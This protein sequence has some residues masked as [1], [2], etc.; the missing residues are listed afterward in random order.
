MN[1]TMYVEG[2]GDTK[3]LRTA[4]RRGFRKFIEKAGFKGCMPKISAS[5]SRKHAYDDFRHAIGKAEGDKF[6]ILLVDSEGPVTKG[7]NSWDHLKVRDQ[8]DRPSDA[9]DESVHLMVQC[10]ESWFLAD[11]DAL[12]S[13]F[14]QGFNGNTL[15]GQPDIESIPKTSLSAD[16][17]NATRQC[18]RKGKYHK[19]RHSFEILAE[20]NPQKV[21]AASPHA[22]RLVDTLKNKLLEKQI[23]A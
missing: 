9:S 10:M 2:G 17:S 14:G 7:S 4:C 20:L 15:S 8:W 21:V 11:K 19:G 13:Y 22:K 18:Q 1:V 16:L 6:I 3:A 5:G 23:D 12:A